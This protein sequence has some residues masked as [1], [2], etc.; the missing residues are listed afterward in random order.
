M[1]NLLLIILCSVFAVLSTAAIILALFVYLNQ[2]NNDDSS[3]DSDQ[4]SPTCN[5]DQLII[6]NYIMGVG[7]D[8]SKLILTPTDGNLPVIEFNLMDDSGSIMTVY[9]NIDGDGGK[10]SLLIKY[11]K[12]ITIA[13]YEDDD[14]PKL[15]TYSCKSLSKDVI[16]FNNDVTI[17][18]VNNAFTI[19][20]SVGAFTFG[21]DNILEIVNL[22]PKSDTDDKPYMYYNGLTLCTIPPPEELS[23]CVGDPPSNKLEDSQNISS[24]TESKDKIDFITFS[25]GYK[26]LPEDSLSLIGEKAKIKFKVEAEDTDRFTVE[27]QNGYFYYS[28]DNSFGWA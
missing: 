27:T 28:A 1:E 19:A 8:K 21:A 23:N 3:N 24:P 14:V 4:G 17:T 7:E 16:T 5:I 22:A 12:S 6:G 11:D 2:N 18:T 25:N 15:P 20:G 26:L 9:T 10:S 13:S